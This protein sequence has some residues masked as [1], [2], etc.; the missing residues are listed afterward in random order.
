MD[1]REGERMNDWQPID[2]APKDGTEV[3]G[4][5]DERDPKIELIR[6]LGA[7][8]VDGDLICKW[9][10]RDEAE[11]PATHWMPL[12]KPPGGHS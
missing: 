9:L 12:P 10:D 2:T 7:D 1:A 6:Y 8:F 4:Y 11:F 5:S 3:L